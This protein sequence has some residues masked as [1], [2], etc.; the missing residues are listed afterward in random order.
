MPQIVLWSN[1]SRYSLSFLTLLQHINENVKN[2]AEQIIKT[3][4]VES[5]TI[6]LEKSTNIIKLNF[7]FRKSLCVCLMHLQLTVIQYVGEQ[8][9]IIIININKREIVNFNSYFIFREIYETRYC[10]CCWCWNMMKYTF[11]SVFLSRCQIRDIRGT[12]KKCN[13]CQCGRRL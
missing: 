1:S 9:T 13:V 11:F 2:K 3:M 5:I 10:C 7:C 6:N 12:T 4:G 8:V